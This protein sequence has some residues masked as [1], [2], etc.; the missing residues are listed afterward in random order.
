MNKEHNYIKAR[1]SQFYWYKDVPLYTQVEEAKFVLY[2]PSGIT[3]GEMRLNNELHPDNLF[4]NSEDKLTG[5]QEAQKAFNKQLEIDVK[6]G[7]PEKIKETL[8]TIVDETLLE[9]RSGSLEGISDT[10]SILI[11][12][13]SRENYTINKLNIL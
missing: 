11:G 13:Y 6:T 1:K 8:I 3:L 2:K 10:V 5:I 12:D 4:I 9:P 7:T